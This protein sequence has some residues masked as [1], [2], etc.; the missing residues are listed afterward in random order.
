MNESEGSLLGI[1]VKEEDAVELV[2]HFNEN[3]EQLYSYHQT[4]TIQLDRTELINSK[5]KNNEINDFEQ[6]SFIE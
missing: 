3:Q 1:C 5:L 2:R 4:T 6:N